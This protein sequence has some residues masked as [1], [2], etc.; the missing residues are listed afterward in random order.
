MWVSEST[1]QLEQNKKKAQRIKS[2]E[3]KDK[4]QLFTLQLLPEIKR[5]L[6]VLMKMLY[7]H[8]I[9]IQLFE[10]QCFLSICLCLSLSPTFGL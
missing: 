6:N 10:K 3:M 1:E 4:H 2:C 7:N 9:H 8:I 5:V